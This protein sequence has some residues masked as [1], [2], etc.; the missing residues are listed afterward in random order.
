M[1]G[2]CHLRLKI[3]VESNLPR[4]LPYKSSIADKL[5]QGFS[6]YT[7]ADAGEDIKKSSGYF[8]VNDDNSVHVK[9]NL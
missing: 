2:F 6:G 4:K 3:V 7:P 8:L 5:I 9:N 1:T